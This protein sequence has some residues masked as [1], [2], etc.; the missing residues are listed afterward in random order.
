M[1]ISRVA[2]WTCQPKVHGILMYP[3]QLLTSNVL[4]ATILGMLATM[5]K[6]LTSATSIPRVLETRAPVNGMKKMCHSSNQGASM[7]RP[8]EEDTPELDVTPEEPPHQKQKEGRPAAKPLK[9]NHHKAFSKESGLIKVARQAY[10]KAH[11]P[12]YEH[13]GSYNLS[14][15]FKEIATSANLMH[16]EVYEVKEVWTGERKLKAT[17]H[18]VKASPKDIHLFRSCNPLNCPRSWA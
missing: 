9:E 4:L 13:E 15:F 11:Q 12:N 14:L 8:E 6:E 1:E 17:H 7:P 18:A 2:L 5:G 10:H 16:S 3:L